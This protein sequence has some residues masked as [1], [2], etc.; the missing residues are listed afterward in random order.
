MRKSITGIG[1][2]DAIPLNLKYV[3]LKSTG[4]A[5]NENGLLIRLFEKINKITNV[6]RRSFEKGC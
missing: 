2:P 4:R 3:R 1:Q 5:L 6:R